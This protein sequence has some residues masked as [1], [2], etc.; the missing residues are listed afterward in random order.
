VTIALLD[1]NSSVSA[2]GRAKSKAAAALLER[3]QQAG[4][5]RPDI[6]SAD[7][8]RLLHG[9]ALATEKLS[10]G[11]EQAERLL[12][13]VLDSLWTKKPDTKPIL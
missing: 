13:F 12:G 5:V 3:A 10:D 2:A 9:I 4:V 1:E 6:T 7:V 11:A 8:G